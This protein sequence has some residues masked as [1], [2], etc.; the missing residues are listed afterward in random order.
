MMNINEL[1]NTVAA[2]D[3]DSILTTST[4]ELEILCDEVDV[5]IPCTYEFGTW[6]AREADINYVMELLG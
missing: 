5:T 6:M 4:G 3:G 1:R 2:H